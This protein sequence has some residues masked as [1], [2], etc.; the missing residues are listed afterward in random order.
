MNTDDKNIYFAVKDKH[1]YDYLCPL[2]AVA[3]RNYV[4]D[5][6]LDECVEKDVVGR[7]AGNID[8]NVT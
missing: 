3:D 7:Y 8:I 1:G 4:S 6:E 5:Q 2:A